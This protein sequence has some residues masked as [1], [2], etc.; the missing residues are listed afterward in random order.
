MLV[1]SGLALA[2]GAVAMPAAAQPPNKTEP[3]PYIRKAMHALKRAAE[4]L[5]EAAHDFGGHRKEALEA[6]EV[7]HRQL[8]LCL[9][10]DRK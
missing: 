5:R 3:H 10:H 6:V 9:E 4:E 2:T 8:R 7:A 1:L